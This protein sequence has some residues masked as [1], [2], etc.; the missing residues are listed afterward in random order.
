VALAAH[1]VDPSGTVDIALDRAS[2]ERRRSG[3]E[4]FWLDLHNRAEAELEAVREAFGF[5]PLAIED[6]VH[7]GQRPKP[8]E[9]DEFV[10][11][12]VYGGRRT[13]TG[14]SRCT[15]TSRTATS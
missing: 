14:S 15:A 3:G 7:F 12:V 13:R 2:L 8:E 5:H 4:V 6:S 11:L 1:L 10:F 9:Y